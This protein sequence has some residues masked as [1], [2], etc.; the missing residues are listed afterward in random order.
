M[1][2]LCESYFGYLL[3]ATKKR[4]V[5]LQNT[6]ATNTT[7]AGFELDDFDFDDPTPLTSPSP[8]KLKPLSY[9]SNKK[10]REEEEL[11]SSAVWVKPRVPG[12]WIHSLQNLIPLSALQGPVILCT[13]H[14]IVYIHTMYI[15]YAEPSKP[16]IDSFVSRDPEMQFANQTS[17]YCR[18]KPGWPSPGYIVNDH[19]YWGH[20]SESIAM[21]VLTGWNITWNN[22]NFPFFI[23][24]YVWL[25]P[26]RSGPQNQVV[27]TTEMQF[28]VRCV[29]SW[30]EW[31][32]SACAYKLD[33]FVCCTCNAYVILRLEYWYLFICNDWWYCVVMFFY[34]IF[35]M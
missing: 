21:N 3:A 12:L 31:Y 6:S 26:S 25:A 5:S 19:I 28:H 29:L 32:F 23:L 20:R 7:G 1:L 27:G 14:I 10:K 13:N 11:T 8:A 34:C 2:F 18:L 17:I 4:K 15:V 16:L 30:K 24:S 22:G 35:C 9:S 33:N